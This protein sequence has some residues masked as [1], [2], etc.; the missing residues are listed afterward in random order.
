VIIANVTG[1]ENI[2][3]GIIL[4]R[5]TQDSRGASSVVN[6]DILRDIVFRCVSL[7][8]GQNFDKVRCSTK[9]HKKSKSAA[10]QR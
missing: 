5:V 9:Q 7:K 10:K 8:Q 1:A 6:L 4:V 3:S 2:S